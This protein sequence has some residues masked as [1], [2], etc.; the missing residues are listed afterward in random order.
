MSLIYR[1]NLSELHTAS[2]PEGVAR[3]NKIGKVNPRVLAT[4][5]S[6]LGVGISH[7]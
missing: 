7:V 1:V 5:F 3:V 4:T 6:T 2:H